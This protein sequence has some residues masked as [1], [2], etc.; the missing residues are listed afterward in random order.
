MR[1]SS[2]GRQRS[3]RSPLNSIVPLVTS[4][5]SA[6]SRLEIAFSVVRLARA[7]GA[8]Q[9]DDAALGHLERHALEHQDHVVVDDLDVVDREV[10]RRRSRRLVVGEAVAGSWS[11]GKSADPDDLAGQS[12]RCAP[13][14][15]AAVRDVDPA[16]PRAASSRRADVAAVA[17]TGA[18]SAFLRAVARRDLLLLRVLGRGFL[19]H[20]AHHR[21]VAGQSASA[22]LNPLPSH[23]WNLTTPPPSWSA[24]VIL[25]GGMR[26]AA[27]SSFRRASRQ[28]EVLEAPAHL[29]ARHHLAL[30]ELLLRL[31]DRLDGDDAVDDAAVVDR[32]LPMRVGSSML[33]LPLA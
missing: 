13:G 17:R 14:S 3:T 29:L 8:E 6:R 23:C 2:F 22:A 31:A 24:Q 26:P 1:T 18:R 15:A 10:R 12:G 30:A 7:V 20:R 28:V 5:R 16:A 27:P 9:R 21:L 25:I 33:P 11:L 19:D 4:P 32:S